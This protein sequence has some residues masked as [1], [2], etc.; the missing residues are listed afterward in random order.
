MKSARF[1]RM[2]FMNK[3]VA[4]L[5]LSA[6]VAGCKSHHR[7]NF[8]D[9]EFPSFRCAAYFKQAS[10]SQQQFDDI[11]YLS[12]QNANCKVILG[13]MY[14]QGHGVPKNIEK[15]KDI[16]E[17]V[18]R[19]APNVYSRLGDMAATGV[20]GPVD[21]VAA[22]DFYE[23]SIAEPGNTA[24]ELKVAEF[25][26]NG[27]GGPQDLQGAL[28]LYFKA[29]S[30]D[31]LQRLRSKGV[32]MTIEQQQQYNKVYLNRMQYGVREK[33]EGIEKALAQEK[34]STP[35][36]KSVQLEL[37]YTPGSLVPV[38]A[39]RQSCGNSS[40]DQKV[41]QGF[42]DYRYPG[43]PILSPEQKNHTTVASVRTDGL[44]DRERLRALSKK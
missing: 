37:T 21:L 11:R 20:G 8:A 19:R 22:R 1:Q 6:L 33:I 17:S 3:V 44:T 42:S 31:N 18:A 10:I 2:P 5:A 27:K 15:A 30:W 26:E 12:T 24:M 35:E 14:E 13:E 38:I 16:Y 36:R 7:S 40:I 9:D 28:K 39:L 43:E 4:V 23:R 41:M 32:V 25:L 34:L 29:D